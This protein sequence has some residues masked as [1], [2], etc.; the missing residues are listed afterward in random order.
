MEEDIKIIEEFIK[1]PM[2]EYREVIIHGEKVKFDYIP[3]NFRPDEKLAQAIQNFLQAYKEDKAA[4]EKL[5][6][7]AQMTAEEFEKVHNL[8]DKTIELILDDL[9]DSGYTKEELFR[10]YENR[11]KAILESQEK[12]EQSR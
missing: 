5:K 8:L 7:Q 10:S 3:M 6:R 1:N 4:I 9:S 12:D 2:P 11:A